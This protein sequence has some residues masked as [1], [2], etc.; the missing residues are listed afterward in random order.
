MLSDNH[1]KDTLGTIGTC[2]HSITGEYRIFGPPGTGK[3]TSLSQQ[4][5]AAVDRFGK[6]SVLV[7]SFS[8]A[9]AAAL[10]G[11]DLPLSDDCVGTLHSHCWRALGRPVIAETHVEEW[12]RR[13]PLL[14]IT[15]AKAAAKLDGEEGG[16]ETSNGAPKGD[17]L[18]SELNRHRGMMLPAE[19]WPGS[20]QAFAARWSA[21]KASRQLLDFCDLVECALRDIRIAPRRPDVIFV[22]EA[23]DLNQMQLNLV[24]MWGEKSEYYVIA[25]D[26]DQTI[27]SWC[28]ATPDGILDPEIPEDHKIFLQQSHRIPQSVHTRATRLIHQVSRRQAKVYAPRSE[29]G[30]CTQISRGGYKSPGYWIL[31]TIAQHIEKKQ[32]VMLLASCSYMLEPVIA[33]LRKSGIPFHNP[34]RTSNGFWNPLRKGR[35]ESSASRLRA[36]LG[37]EP[38]THRE[39][40]LW[41]EWVTPKGNLR[42]GAKELIWESED[43]LVV[44]PERIGDLFENSAVESLIAASGDPRRL[45]EWWSR[46]IAPTFRK[47]IEFPVKVAQAGG[48]ASLVDAPRVIVGTIH[49]VKGG[50]A[51]VVFLFPD[52]SRAADITYARPGSARDSVI[53]LFYVGMTRARETLYICQKE[54]SMAVAL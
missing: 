17:F 8:R 25:A 13:N 35:R 2:D 45:S 20:L 26:D 38:W 6:D 29:E 41:V 14:L 40:K 5:R 7:T 11:K 34:Y 53:R 1:F 50:E 37:G 44:T 3:T 46:R 27:Y 9:A 49:S 12:N 15:P 42:P 32:S 18:L 33:V 19:T 52:L 39:L 54:S 31:K 24:R 4:I 28:G 10:R 30:V 43:N 21:Y 47:R 16:E 36:L 51:D 23:Q 48:M 22:D